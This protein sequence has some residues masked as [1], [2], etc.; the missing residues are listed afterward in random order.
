MTERERTIAE[1]E[2]Q[3]AHTAALMVALQAE[4][5]WARLREQEGS[6]TI[7]GI[8]AALDEERAE[9]DRKLS[10]IEEKKRVFLNGEPPQPG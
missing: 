3:I 1:I 6:R 10:A 7:E 9:I 2:A 5:K 8:M 4:L